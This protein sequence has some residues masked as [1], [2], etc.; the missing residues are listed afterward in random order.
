MGK[1]IV[2]HG[3]RHE[4]QEVS[5]QTLES[6]T[7]QPDEFR[8]NVKNLA[9]EADPEPLPAVETP[10]AAEASEQSATPDAGKSS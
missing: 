9:D 4:K 6:T 7:L 10:V 3:T 5:V 1:R 2:E 8:V